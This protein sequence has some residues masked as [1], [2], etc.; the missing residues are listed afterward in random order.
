MILFMKKIIFLLLAPF[1]AFWFWNETTGGFS[2]DS[3]LEAS[4]PGDETALLPEQSFRFWTYGNQSFVFLSEDGKWVLKIFK[5]NLGNR[6][7]W[8]KFLP[9]LSALDTLRYYSGEQ[10]RWRMERTF[11]AY[12]L[13]WEK[14]RD[15]SVLEAVHLGKTRMLAPKLRLIDRFGRHSIVD[16]NRIVFVLQRRVVPM[17]QLWIQELQ[18][19]NIS[20]IKGQI[21]ALHKMYLSEYARG[22]YDRD[23]NFLVNTGIFEGRAVRH[24]LGKLRNDE[25]MKD[26]SVGKKDWNKIAWK[27]ID[28]W[29]RDHAPDMREDIAKFLKSF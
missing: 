28:P 1:L 8:T 22:L 11:A 27:K 13:A 15:N 18:T 21:R 9:P 4:A 3:L 23:H 14:N 17:Q 16:P 19:G 6:P 5:A 29:F 26:P 20:A 2:P 12:R 25:R 24:D 10:K 7:F